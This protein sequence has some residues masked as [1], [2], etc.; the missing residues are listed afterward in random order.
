M[1]DDQTR[2]D[3]LDDVLGET[4]ARMDDA[5]SAQH[6]YHRGNG[7]EKSED[8]GGDGAGGTATATDEKAEKAEKDGHGSADGPGN[9]ATDEKTGKKTRPEDEPLPLL[10]YEDFSEQEFPERPDLITGILPAAES[11]LVYGAPRSCKS[12]LTME[13]AISVA[14]GRAFLDHAEYAVPEGLVVILLDLENPPGRLNKRIAASLASKGVQKSDLGGRLIILNRLVMEHP[15]TLTPI[16]MARLF[17]AIGTHKPDLVIMDNVRRAM[18]PGK[19]EK[20]SEDMQPIANQ[21]IESVCDR[22]GCALVIVHHDRRDESSYSGSG[23]LGS[24]PANTIHVQADRTLRVSQVICDSMRN[25]EPFETFMIEIDKNDMALKMA[26]AAKRAAA[27]KS[28]ADKITDA[29]ATGKQTVAALAILTGSSEFLVRK[30]IKGLMRWGR[31]IELPP[32]QDADKRAGNQARWYGL[33][34]ADPLRD[35]PQDCGDGPQ[36]GTPDALTPE[37]DAAPQAEASDVLQDVL[38][39]LERLEDEDEDPEDDEEE[40]GDN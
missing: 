18:P 31:I 6:S 32:D 27:P 17:K 8:P 9:N 4:L 2:T 26:S 30:E 16:N 24:S 7:S 12:F 1:S 40:G 38:A 36:Q 3:P 22:A 20:K 10:S 25:A 13:M 34:A 14:L 37:D 29:L 5:F 39:E 35:D 21:L 33:A 19:D 11:T 28:L 15:W 23:S